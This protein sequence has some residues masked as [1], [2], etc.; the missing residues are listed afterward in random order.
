MATV[1]FDLG[2]YLEDED[3]LEIASNMMLKVTPWLKKG[4]PYFGQWAQLF[5]VMTTKPFEVA[6]L[7]EKAQ[8]LGFEMQHQYLPT[9][10]FLG[11]KE[12]N[13]PLLKQKLVDGETKIYVCKDK[14]CRQPETT[15]E[16]AL[17]HFEKQ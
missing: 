14:V 3:Y 7:G 17:L 1:L 6:I 5:G 2:N 16:K 11:G 10:L 13:L 8:D 9:A 15:V 12:E 4:A